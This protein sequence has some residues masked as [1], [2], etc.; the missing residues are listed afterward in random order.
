[1]AE[2]EDNSMVIAD[3]MQAP[4]MLGAVLAS[5]RAERNF[6]IEDIAN[7]L[8]LSSRQ[9][10]ALE[11]DDFAALP[12]AM[13]TR[14]FIRNYARLL[15]IDPD[16]LLDIYRNTAP[17]QGPRA[18][19][20]QSAN[21]PISSN[22]RRPWL[23]YIVAS[24]IVVALAL[25]W[26]LYFDN[27]SVRITKHKPTEPAKI[28]EN[29]GEVIEPLPVAALSAAERE[30]DSVNPQQNPVAAVIT[31]NDKPVSSD[32]AKQSPVAETTSAKLKFIFSDH[33][34]VSVTDK[35]NKEIFNKT[36]AAGSMDSVEGQPPLK[37]VIGNVAGSQ[38]LYNDKPVD[39]VPYT[40]LNVAHITL[41]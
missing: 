41:E 17:S 15:D 9:V 26:L 28:V 36:K 14:G 33:T 12:E 20:I 10:I 21:I 27:S 4:A 1:M 7:R 23:V 35:D 37:V 19:T 5:A 25:V 39:L 3:E 11:N 16:P 30:P 18:I 24:L 29:K 13:I 40:K 6:S 32:A 22:D 38:L 31:G 8:R 34:W 2:I